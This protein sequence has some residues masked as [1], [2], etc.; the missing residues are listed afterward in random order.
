M[1]LVWLLDFV[2]LAECSV[3]SRAAEIRNVTQPA[4]TRRIKKLEYAVGTV[5]FDR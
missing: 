4:F 2:T 1:E 3:F 5:L